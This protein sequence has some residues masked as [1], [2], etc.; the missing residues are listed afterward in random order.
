MQVWRKARKKIQNTFKKG[1]LMKAKIEEV[2]NYLGLAT[3][4]VKKFDAE[5]RNL[6][7]LGL[8]RQERDNLDSYE[9][10]ITKKKE[11]LITLGKI[12]KKEILAK[13]SNK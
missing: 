10:D 4:T 12:E 13:R 7:R 2:A 3:I 5:D 1:I 9:V 11:H 8:Y 6:M